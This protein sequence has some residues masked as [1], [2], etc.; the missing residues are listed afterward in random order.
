MKKIVTSLICLTTVLVGLASCSTTNNESLFDKDPTTFD[1]Y[2]SDKIS[3]ADMHVDI[4]GKTFLED[5]IEKVD[6]KSVTD[7]DTAVFYTKGMSDS[8]TNPLKKEHDYV[9]LR[10][11]GID[12]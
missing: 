9:T 7:G 1:H 2:Y 3:F 12:K 11:L 6:I 10:F 5:R 8:F 4:N